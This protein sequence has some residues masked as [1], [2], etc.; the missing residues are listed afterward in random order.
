VS[1]H[2]TKVELI[3][4]AAAGWLAATAAG[5]RS[6][7]AGTR[8]ERSDLRSARRTRRALGG[9]AIRGAVAVTLPPAVAAEAQPIL[10]GAACRLLAARLDRDAVGPASRAHYGA[11]DD[12]AN[13]SAALIER[14][15]APVSSRNGDGRR[16]GG[17]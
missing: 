11:I 7:Q 4:G 8:D 13:Q 5:K 3:T 15:I 14:H 16:G 17:E 10:D 1:E 9:L 12:G 2:A 6:S